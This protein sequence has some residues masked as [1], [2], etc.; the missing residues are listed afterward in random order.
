M[1]LKYLLKNYNQNEP[2]FLSDIKLSVTNTY[3]RQ[4]FKNLCDSGK[5]QRFDKG[6]Y[7]LNNSKYRIKGGTTL[8]ASEVAKYKYISRK[9]SVD[10][11]YSGFT[12]ANQLGLT[13]QVPFTI[14]IV[15]NN[16]SAKCREVNIK[17]QKVIIRK[18]RTFITSQNSIVLQFLDLL[19]DL[20]QYSDFE[21]PEITDKIYSYVKKVGISR[22]DVDKYI[23]LF[24]DR[25][26][27]YIYEM[28]LYN[29]FA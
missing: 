20:E 24:P 26:Y 19:K 28:R 18:P 21:L 22:A 8:S 29:A 11:Y 10:G 3:L 4:M 9:S 17:N 2:I 15:S 6:I 23:P 12:F 16:A 1:L 27:K 14:E 25:I 13:T 5:I 7:Y